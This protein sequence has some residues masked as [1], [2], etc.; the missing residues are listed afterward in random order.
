MICYCPSRPI[1]NLTLPTFLMTPRLLTW[2]L[3]SLAP[4]L[5]L[6]PLRQNS[7]LLPNLILP[8][9]DL[10]SSSGFF[11]A[12]AVAAT[13]AVLP[14]DSCCC[15]CGVLLWSSLHHPIVVVPHFCPHHSNGQRSYTVLDIVKYDTISTRSSKFCA[16]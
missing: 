4:L 5:C 10:S 6:L 7:P 1:P 9:E 8:S 16:S 2:A 15:C 13:A 14:V 3:W 12:M 11:M